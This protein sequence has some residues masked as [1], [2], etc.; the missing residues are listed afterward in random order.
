M[1]KIWII[2]HHASPPQYETRIRNNAMA[3]YLMKAGYDVTIFGASTIHNTS[4][5][6]IS[7]G[8]LYIK[9]RYGDL[10][11]VHV[12]A[13]MYKG[14]GI[15]RKLNLFLYPINLLRTVKKIKEKPDYIINDLDITA[16]DFPFKIAKYAKAPIITEVRDLWPESIIVYGY[17]KRTSI[18]AK[19]L[20]AF[21]R[22]MYNKS[23]R[24]V[25]TMQG[26]PDYIANQGWKDKI[27]IGKA[28]YINNGLDLELFNYNRDKYYFEDEDLS[29]KDLFKVV[30]TGSI[31]TVNNVGKLLD[32]AKK[33]QIKDI[34]FLIWGDGDKLSEL[35]QRVVDEKI[36]NVIF[37]GR[38]EKKYIPSIVSQADL[39]FAHNEASEIFKYGISFNKIFDY[40]AAGKPILCDFECKY[41]PVIQEKAG[42]SIESGKINEIAKA[43]EK[44]SCMDKKEYDQYCMRALNAAKDYDFSVLTL[45]MIKILKDL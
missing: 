42:R 13:P 22:R 39:N 21:E 15:K 41:N 34:C 6:L 5:N 25:Y 30:Y 20:Y 1:K 27:D 37:K 10:K 7:N 3:K 33:I 8:A 2:T 4:I 16:L 14:N 12:N 23:D 19:V 35:K 29:R 38:V 45:S 44:F 43:I 9:K 17:L 36:E 28:T 31:R 24:I 32:I 11:Y 40:F 26:W 18:T